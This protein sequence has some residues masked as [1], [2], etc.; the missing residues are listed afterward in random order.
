MCITLAISTHVINLYQNLASKMQKLL[1]L[2][3]FV[4]QAPIGTSP[5][6]LA[7]LAEPYHF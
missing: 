1:H 2:L 3:W 5:K 7:P 4:P 6:D